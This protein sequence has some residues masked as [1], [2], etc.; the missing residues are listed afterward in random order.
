MGDLKY[1]PGTEPESELIERILSGKTECFEQL[2]RPHVSR[3]LAIV[4]ASL[5]NG[6]DA[7]DVAQ[8]ILIKAFT[9]LY[10]FRGEAQFSSW[11]YRIA[12]N[13]IRQYRRRNHLRSERTLT[14]DEGVVVGQEPD[15][16]AILEKESIRTA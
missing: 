5:R 2:V 14:L 16:P 6:A 12:F 3:V 1:A 15:A 8:E 7:D 13:E 10:Q 9:K 4:R 11:L